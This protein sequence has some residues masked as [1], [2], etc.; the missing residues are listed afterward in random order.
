VVYNSDR[1]DTSKAE[2]RYRRALYTFMRRTSP[3]PSMMNYD[4]PTGEVC[5]VRRIRTNTPLQALTTLNDPVSMEAAEKLAAR[6][7]VAG[8]ARATAEK[9]FQTALVRPA[10]KAET[11]RLVESHKKAR[12]ELKADP[13]A[14]NKLLRFSDNLYA[15]D[16]DVTLL[17][18]ARTQPASWRHTAT[19]PGPQWTAPDFDDQAWPSAAG[20][21]GSGTR[22][23]DDVKLKVNWD[24]DH[25]WLR[26]TVDLAAAGAIP[27]R[28][29][30]AVRTNAQVYLYVNGV[31]GVEARWECNGYYD[32]ALSPGG[33]AAFKLGRNVIAV[34]ITRN[35]AEAGLQF[36]DGGLYGTRPLETTKLTSDAL[37]RAAWVVVANTVLNLDEMV[38][39]R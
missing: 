34:M 30:L 4:A 29:R 10:A 3:Y 25:L 24:T 6:T 28:I 8:N 39:R 12:A 2:D 31:Q 15:E 7:V 23:P 5:T 22:S 19:E 1:W 37:D 38:T 33:L 21:F 20:P 11:D 27:E 32:Y 35:H 26:T 13:A 18:D 9:L 17:A 14:A 16:R 36:F